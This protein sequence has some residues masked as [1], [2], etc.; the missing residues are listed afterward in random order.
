MI[1]TTK[2]TEILSKIAEIE[3][4][5][6]SD[7]QEVNI[8]LDNLSIGDK[9]N[10]EQIKLAVSSVETVVQQLSRLDRVRKNLDECKIILTKAQSF[11]GSNK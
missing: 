8:K 7:I 9:D 11:Y 6:N 4:A 5:I 10:F 1:T 2:Q 3:S